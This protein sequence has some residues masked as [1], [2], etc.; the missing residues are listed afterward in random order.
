MKI[1]T[2]IY[3]N[4]AL[5]C[6]LLITTINSYA[7][8][9]YASTEDHGSSSLLCIGCTV[10]NPGNAVDAST[11]TFSTLNL[12]IA[13]LGDTYQELKFPTSGGVAAGTPVTV[14]LGSG[15]KLVSATVLGGIRLQAYN[16]TNAVGSPVLASTLLTALSNN[17]QFEVSITPSAKYDRIRVT[18]ISGIVGALSNLYVYDGYYNGNAPGACNSAIDELHGIS[19]GLLNLGVNVGGVANPQNAIDGNINTSST[20]STAIGAV[21]A[22]AQQTIIYEAP[23]VKGDSIRL[24]LSIPG[25]LLQAG[26]LSDITVSTSNGPNGTAESYLLNSSLLVVRILDPTN[27]NPHVTVTYAPNTVFD[28]VQ[29]TLGGLVNVLSTLNLYEAQKLI[30]QPVIKVNNTVTNNT[31]ICNG[32]TATLTAS[33]VP[34]ITNTTFLWYASATATTPL[35]TG[36]SFTTP[37]LTATTTYYVAAMRSGCT[38]QSERAKVT[39]T[40]NAIPANPVI[41]NNA[42]TVCPGS[43]ATFTA[44]AVTGVTIN[45]YTTATGGTAVGTGNTFTTGALTQTTS[46]YAEAVAGG[47]C[48]SPGRT[49]VTAT[50]SPL[51]AAPTLTAPTQTICDGD[52]AVLSIATPAT[53]VT[54]NWYST[55]TGGTPI[56]TGI[57]YT[58]PALHATTNYY[59]EAVNA[60][61][62]P[63]SARTLATVTV[64]PKPANPVL[65]ANNLTI[66]AGQTA[67]IQV[68]NAQTGITYNW[69]TSATAA[70]SIFSGTTYTTPALFTNTTYYVSAV[71][72]TGCQSANRTAITIN[73]TVN[74]N[75]PCSFANAQTNDVNGICIGCG[76]TQGTLATDADTTTAST[77]SVLAGLIGAYAE[78]KLTFQQPGFAGDTLKIV[79]GSTANLLSASVLGNFQV[80]LLNGTTQVA[81]YALN[82]ALIKVS[83]LTGGTKYAIYVPAP[84]SYT[85]AVIRLN[86]G[87]LTALT[88]LQVYYALQQY[89][90]PVFNPGASEICKGSTAVLNITSPANGIF[91]WYTAPTGGTLAFTGTSFTT[92]ALNANTTYY[93]A[94]TRGSCVSTVR[95]PVAVLVDNP[96][97]NP[98]VTP[99]TTT[100]ISGQT[101][102]F[103]ATVGNNVVVKWYTAASG[104]TPIFTGTTFTTPALTTPTT[105]YAES[106]LGSCVSPGRTPA[107]VNIT[108]IVVPNVT[109]TPSTQTV[110]P[111]TTATLTASSTTPGTVFNWYTTPT[112]GTSIFTGATFTTPP[113]FAAT[114]YYAEAV[115][116]ATGTKSA[117]R[118]SGV[119][120]V[121]SSAVS[122]TPCDAAIDQTSATN[123][124]CLLC[125][126]SNATGSVDNDR[127]TF[128]QLDVPVG[129]LNASAQQTLRF[130]GTGRAG[131]TIVMELGV[132]GSLASVNV[133]SAINLATYNGATY[134]NDRFAINTSL[135]TITLLNGTSR[136]RYAFV[137]AHDFDRVEIRLNSVA[138]VLSALNIYDA[139]EEVAKPVITTASVTA[140]AG[141]QATLTA[142]VPS[143]VTVK[144]YTTATGGTPV[145]TGATF[146][147]PA[148]NATTTY[149]AEASRTADGCTQATRTPATVTVT[150]VPAAPVVAVPTQTVCSGSPATFTATA[151][152]GV[153]FSWYTAATGGT[154]VFTGNPFT[155]APLT[156]SA[157]YYVEANGSGQCGSSTRTLV[158]A[159]V[160]T[161]PIVPTVSQTPVQTCSGS[162][163]ILT[164]TSTQPGVTFNWYT[165]ATG[166]TP[167]FTGVQYTTPALTANTSYY[168]ETSLG[169][170]VSP[171]RAKADVN[172]NPTPTQPVVTV[173]PSNAQVTAGQKATLTATST[174]AG[175]IFNWYTTATGG[176]PVFTGASFTTPVL[177]SNITYYVD[178]Q[179]AAT[180]CTSPQRTAVNIT[181]NT[182]FS[183]SCD[184]ASTQTTSNSGVL[185]IGC[186]VTTPNFSVD[187]DTTNFSV[188]NL[189]LSLLNA[190]TSQEL[191]FGDGGIKG[192]TVRIRIKVP[193]SLLT[194]GILDHIQVASYSN[195][196]ATYNGDRIN[197]SSSLIK[198]QLLSG[199]QDAIIKFAPQVAYDAVEVRLGNGLVSLLN[200][201][202]IL[203]ATKEVE[204]PKLTASTVNICSGSTATFTVSNARAGLTY[205]WYT[206]ATG[207]AAVFTGTTFTTGALTATTTYYVESSRT[208]NSCPNP[209]R[210]AATANV[211]PS[212]VN[213]ILAQN[214]VQ[215]CSGSSVTLSVTNAGTSTVQWYDAATGGNLLFTGA[216]YQVT[217]IADITYYAD[218]INGTCT[219]PSRVAAMVHVNQTPSQPGV[220]ASSLTVCMGSPAT[221][222]IL[223]PQAGVTY[224]Y[225]TVATGGI[226]VGT[227]N[228]YT[229][230]AITQNTIYY[231][232]ATNATSGCVNSGGRTQVAISVTNQVAAPTLSATQTQVCSGGSVT[233]SVTNPVVG[234]TYN[235]YTAATA[236]TLAFTGTTITVNNLTSNVSY[237]VEAVNSTGCTSPTRTETDITVQAPPTPPQVQVPAGG[238]SVCAGSSAS[239]SIANPQA[240]DVYRWYNAATGGTLLFTGTQFNTPA[241]TVATT[242]YVEA[243]SA[244]NCNP[245]TRTAVTIG[246]NALPADPVLASNNVAVCTGNTATLQ[247]SSPQ[248]GVTYSWYDSATKTNLLFTGATYITGPITSTTDFFV[249]ASNAAG[250]GSNNLTQAQVTIQAPPGAPVVANGS[251]VQSCVGS[252][253]TLTIANPAGLTYNWY[254]AATG[255]SPVATGIS[256]TTGTLTANTSYF[257]EAVNSTGCASSAR[258]EVDIKVNAL[259]IAPT[260]TAQGG[261]SSPSVCSGSGVTLTAT[262]TTPNVTFNWYT[263]ATGGTPVFTGAVYTT[264]AISA[265]TTYYVEAV[266]NTGGCAS[267]TRTAVQISITQPPATPT[268]VSANV[269][270]CIGSAATLA[271]ANPQTGLTY[272]W[273]NS[274]AKTTLL[275]TGPSYTTAA[276]TTN[277]TYYVEALNGT[278]ASPAL[279]SVQVTAVTA[280]GSP[281]VA[282]GNTV[283]SCAGSTVTLTISNPVAGFTY[284]WYTTATGGTPVATGTSFTTP[285]LTAN[286]SY[287][288]EAANGTGCNSAART[289]VDIDVNA[290]PTPPTVTAQG[291]SS[292][293][294]VCAGSAVT[295]TATSTTANVNFNWYTVATGGTPIFTGAVYT[296]GA[297]TVNTIYYVEAVSNTGGCASTTRTAVQITTTQ[298]PATPTVVSANVSAC[299]GSTATLSVSSPQSSLTYNWYDSATKTNLLFTGPNYATGPVTASATYYVEAVNGSCN[300]P[301]LASVKVT[302]VA[303]P[304]APLVTNGNAVTTCTG[305]QTTLAIDNPQSGFTYNWYTT[306]TGGTSVAT[307]I[308]FVT[309]V[310]NNNTTY[311][312]EATN[313][314]GCPSASRTAVNIT[315]SPA[316]TAPQI[317]SQNLS[318]CPGVTATL[319]ATVS[320]PGITVKWYTTATGGT[321]V[322]NGTSFIT[323]AL[324]AN[325]TYYAEA[326]NGT[327]GCTS[328]TRTQATVSILQH[329]ASPVVTVS[330]ATPT[331]LTFAWNAV[332]GATGYQ[333]SIN[334][335]ATFTDPSS[336]SNGLTHTIAGLQPGQSITIVV[337]ALGGSQCQTSDN[338][339]PV[340][341]TTTNPNGDAIFVP[342][343]FTP[344]GD[345]KNDI[346]YVYGTAIKS[347]KFY[348]YDQ[349]GELIYSSLNQANGWDGTY[350]GTKQPVGVYVYYLDATMNDGQQIKK[351]GTIT[352]LR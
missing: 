113:V 252:Q 233:L 78:Q 312:A 135:I 254:T 190:Y 201:L 276:V 48:V 289:E 302:P 72:A 232:E 131:D 309:P 294:T 69:Y 281:V 178:A 308:D 137:A 291:G 57:N 118:A 243:A 185:C 98:V 144:W 262:S 107:Q 322:A 351:K 119:V 56:Y 157:T 16:G 195:N 138:S 288:V 5:L 318:I 259:P 342:N 226:A 51:P 189:P 2:L 22:Y 196:G 166:G 102:T 156:A 175:A 197:V 267:T 35:F 80:I 253:V 45:W 104:G 106:S 186:T 58:T 105:Y 173:N 145:F 320:D 177:T 1:N 280:P 143:Y 40:V 301:A 38:D 151:V 36:S 275:F 60:T 328:T 86:S 315:V 170:C 278:C 34:N 317:T 11:E 44:N 184:F 313:N 208:A 136:F 42:V 150:P 350:K 209:N 349:W 79:V 330:T 114:T 162:S 149:Y 39:V 3:R 171:T 323:P 123:G 111:G 84:A 97:P 310:L 68:T 164:A 268:V 127:N 163:A 214:N 134:N 295:L 204:Q 229:T 191:I 194:A 307:G 258:T 128:S 65:A 172:V 327:S 99:S 91:Q 300:S 219:S 43:S 74:N 266:S 176:T 314:T 240:N 332:N 251:T 321:A 325:T 334:N 331:S 326:V 222:N 76:V 90:K 304:G 236:G 126:I 205:K 305:T 220:Q 81:S 203:Y 67:T 12:G 174:T 249:S 202:D 147:T 112:G 8:R 333:V 140:C 247:V 306:A 216:N 4:I 93:I 125:G 122:P 7:Q 37:V 33:T 52:V 59:A 77:I 261:S 165:T 337:R 15:D 338:S 146:N 139:S 101:A 224:K 287:F 256:F 237:F 132:P 329:L 227:G 339:A 181:V 46:Y 248:A 6:L 336:G 335:G 27:A 183:T 32:G 73:V 228:S 87:A 272:N 211:S 61:G 192:D 13:V 246:I 155:T 341:G 282:N 94:Y 108:P 230:A 158:T 24:T 133:L 244:G 235:W 298:S 64:S 347:M 340:T 279:A 14:K 54:Y 311:Y 152:T 120:N 255:G 193:A 62:C 239:I 285:V 154:A 198:I 316:P 187:Q 20:L 115:V 18:L 269:S 30:P 231:V 9:I 206:T 92:P 234:L 218:L 210:V 265:A 180:G 277:A 257:V 299:M 110:N 270:A 348:V 53:G 168:V 153:T 283:Q 71:N 343:A 100:I 215:V 273:Y 296:T 28:R 286:T 297:I 26:V 95:Y 207:G 41:T 199:N 47:T 242:Y 293:P 96:P 70:T 31:S 83:L 212:P 303:A 109:V 88:T 49:Q 121:N 25:T 103:T 245:S 290:L 55:A 10:T 250:C 260:V 141:T 179:L 29:V 75:T 264:P 223:S 344:N 124:I 345:G 66:S 116:T 167:V 148:L 284:N 221:I 324:T 352:L 200:S 142:T 238:L 274:A 85:S 130:A 225:Y 23:S 63:S 21:G 117:S 50:I 292:S 217:P 19:A 159:N 346:E 129:L 213:P 319:Q 160:A 271:V 17:N 263:V 89:P 241:L 169:S 188:L 161:S 82:N 182:I